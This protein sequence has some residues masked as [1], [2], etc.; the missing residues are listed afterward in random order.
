MT[1]VVLL[2]LGWTLGFVTG[3]IILG[4]LLY[5]KHE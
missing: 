2:L 1:P 5:W 3:G 4:R